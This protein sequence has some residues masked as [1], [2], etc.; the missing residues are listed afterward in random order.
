MLYAS[1][2][3]VKTAEES[4][5]DFVAAGYTMKYTGVIRQSQQKRFYGYLRF[6]VLY[7]VFWPTWLSSGNTHYV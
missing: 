3:M 4:R 2:G 6:S 5:M 7:D 1:N